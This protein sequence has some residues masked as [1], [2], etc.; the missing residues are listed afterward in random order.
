MKLIAFLFLEAIEIMG[1]VVGVTDGD[2]IKVLEYLDNGQKKL[3]NIKLNNID[4]PEKSQLFSKKFKQ[5]LAS[6]IQNE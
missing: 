1:Q 5:T 2:I 6:M 3:Y 4:A